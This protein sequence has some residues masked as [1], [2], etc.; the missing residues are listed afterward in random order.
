[1][2]ASTV[3][4]AQGLDIVTTAE[5]IETEEQ[6]E[7]MRKAGVDLGQGYLFGR[8]VPFAQLDVGGEAVK[9][10]QQKGMVA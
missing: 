10:K 7:Y 9:P 5:G 3:A 2:V 6:F 4:L 8:P 1:V